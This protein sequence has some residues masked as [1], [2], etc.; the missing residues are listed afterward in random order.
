M[1]EEE[2]LL[3][4]GDEQAC[5]D[6][7]VV[8]LILMHVRLLSEHERRVLKAYILNTNELVSKYKALAC[9]KGLNIGKYVPVSCKYW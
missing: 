4:E 1:N 5:G 7:I 2:C 8:V 9:R 3:E 6:P